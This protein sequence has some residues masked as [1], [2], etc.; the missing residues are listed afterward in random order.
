MI[1]VLWHGRGGQGAFTA[2]R[3]LG[4]AASI[5][6]GSYALAFPSF[7]PER[8]GAPM[9]AFTK[10]SDAPIG[11]RSAIDC[12]DYVI[13]LDD[14]LLDAAG[15]AWAR[16]L[17][18][19]GRVLVNSV[20]AY[21]DERIVAIDANGLSTEVLGRAI[22]NTVFLGALS[23]LCASVSEEHVVE[24]IRQYMPA[25]LHAKNE[26][27][28]AEARQRVLARAAQGG[29][30]AAVAEA[31]EGAA[32]ARGS[33]GPEGSEEPEA[34]GTPGTPGI[35][36]APANVSRETSRAAG[37]GGQAGVSVPEDHDVVRACEH[38]PVLRS[39]FAVP[40]SLDPAEYASTTC[41]PAGHLVAKN[42]GWRNER[43]V[44]N[45]E[46]CTGCLQCYLYCPDGTIY[47][48]A[49]AAARD[50]DS[51][52]AQGAF[53]PVAVDYDFCKGCGVCAKACKFG[54]IRMIPESEA[55]VR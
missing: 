42:A 19:G 6:D 43:P 39:H 20:K 36:D 8:R 21:A 48:A 44:I 34:F 10:V 26:R 45:A 35:P 54:A 49:S 40:P 9:R 27:I 5:A 28:V 32:S 13:Y 17:K 18:P 38:I 1:E 50:E 51:R 11:D 24:A 33:E 15:E 16:E 31:K 37:E 55:D 46:A 12:A 30:E 14:T 52:N 7:G 41:Y 29:G 2:A 22:P 53:A 4:A 47:K 25:K 23:V 3:L